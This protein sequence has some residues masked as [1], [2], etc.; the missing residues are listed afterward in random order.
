MADI[1][2]SLRVSRVGEEGG[3]VSSEGFDEAGEE[4]EGCYY[5][6]RVEGRVVRDV[7]E[8][9]P[10]DYIVCEFVDRR[11]AVD[12]AEGDDVDVYVF[13]VVGSYLAEDVADDEEKGRND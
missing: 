2:L 6:A 10:H 1:P 8:D 7:V 9:A 4:A 11:G 13:V 3:A 5:A 12:H